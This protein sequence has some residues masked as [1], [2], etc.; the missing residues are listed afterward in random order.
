M[1]VINTLVSNN[2]IV[3]R[4]IKKDLELEQWDNKNVEFGMVWHK[5]YL[6]LDPL[7]EGS[8]GSY[9]II[10]ATDVVVEDSNAQR[11]VLIPFEVTDVTELGISTV[12]ESIFLYSNPDINL[13]EEKQKGK[14]YPLNTAENIKIKS[15]SYELH[16]QVCVGTPKEIGSDNEEV[17]YRF[18]FIKN[19]NPKFKVLIEDD[20]GWDTS[21][22]LLKG[23][24]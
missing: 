14:H 4:S 9:F 16:F 8:F 12:A 17:Y 23:R 3:I 1:I 22:S 11:S 6:A 21:T 7:V 24:K 5:N 10:D 13:E 20:Y 15:G 18:N 19:D 2:Q